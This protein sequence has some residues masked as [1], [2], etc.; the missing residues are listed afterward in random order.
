LPALDFGNLPCRA[1]RPPMLAL[2]FR[3]PPR[4]RSASSILPLSNF[5]AAVSWNQFRGMGFFKVRD[6][7]IGEDQ[8]VGVS[9]PEMSH[10]PLK[11]WRIKTELARN[12]TCRLEVTG[13]DLIGVV[14]D[15]SRDGI[16]LPKQA[17]TSR[18]RS[19]RRWLL[20]RF[21]TSPCDQAAGLERK[22]LKIASVPRS[23]PRGLDKL[24]P[25]PG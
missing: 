23:C 4:L 5:F 3:Q 15:I 2:A 6:G 1:S 9:G 21:P 22:R 8:F 14:N 25:V 13:G 17:G 20:R 19:S 24:L 11:Q 10:N 16:P 12:S 18:S 7:T